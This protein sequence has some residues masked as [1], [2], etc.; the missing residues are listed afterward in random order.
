MESILQH[1]KEEQALLRQE[2]EALKKKEKQYQE[3]ILALEREKQTLGEAAELG[4][5][6]IKALKKQLTL[7]MEMVRQGEHELL[8]AKRQLVRMSEEAGKEQMRK[9]VELRR[10]AEHLRQIKSLIEGK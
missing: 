8:E 4:S 2:M 3:Q 7:S 9:E 10:K 5:E 1:E 6:Q